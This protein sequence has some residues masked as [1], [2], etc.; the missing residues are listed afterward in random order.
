[1]TESLTPEEPNNQQNIF[2]CISAIMR[3]IGAVSKNQTNQ[4]QR[5]K[6]RGIDDVY[7]ALHNAMGKHGVFTTSTINEVEREERQSKSG[8]VLIYTRM[9]ITYTFHAGDGSCVCTTVEGEGM[10]SGDKSS[11]KAMAVAHKYALLQIFMI[12]T[13]ETKDPDSESHEVA[14][15]LSIEQQ[16]NIEKLIKSSGKN[17]TAFLGWIGAKSLDR[18]RADQ[19]DRCVKAL[20]KKRTQPE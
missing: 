6:Y 3:D 8:G 12:P 10:D 1:M 11:N 5:F 7:N 2:G 18:I 4:Q 15:R 16:A 9:R 17:R 20:E 19:Y 13:E 14:A